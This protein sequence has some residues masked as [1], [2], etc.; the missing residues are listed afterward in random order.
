MR[1]WL[2]RPASTAAYASRRAS[3]AG[4][5]RPL[6]PPQGLRHWPDAF[7]RAPVQR[8]RV[9]PA[10]RLEA[11]PVRLA[12]PGRVLRVR[13]ALVVRLVRRVALVPRLEP[14]PASG[15]HLLHH[16]KHREY[17]QGQALVRDQ[18]HQEPQRP[19]GLAAPRGHRGHPRGVQLLGDSRRRDRERL[20]IRFRQRTRRGLGLG[21]LGRR[22]PQLTLLG[23]RLS[24]P[25]TKDNINMKRTF[26]P[27][28]ATLALAGLLAGCGSSSSSSSSTA[29]SASGS[30]GTATPCEA[31]LL[32]EVA[33][34]DAALATG[35]REAALGRRPWLLR[36]WRRRSRR[37]WTCCQPE[38][39]GCD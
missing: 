9:Q 31:R 34:R 11:P 8:V 13:L 26:L 1:P 27:L 17:G 3:S 22:G 23:Q 21:Q 2:A 10:P 30:G 4:R 38:V 37:G 33:R 25:S 6:P 29:A 39:P 16:R 28:L 36:W 18:G 7:A 35:G 24:R 19:P 14:S 15:R 12:A 20:R 32:P 5:Q